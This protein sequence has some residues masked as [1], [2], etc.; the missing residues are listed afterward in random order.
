MSKV[1]VVVRREFL[2]TVRR[3][4]YLIVTFG[5]PFFAA[6]Y[7]GLFAL[8]PLI[9]RAQSARSKKGM[10]IVDLSGV[11]R[12]EVMEALDE[13]ARGHAEEVRS[14]AGDL[15]AAGAGA[16]MARTIL[17]AVT[18]A[19]RLRIFASREEALAALGEEGIDR[20]YLIPEDYL[21]TGAVEVYRTDSETF[22][23]GRARDNRVVERLLSRSL[24]A[25]RIPEDVRT[26]AERPIARE[27]LSAYVVGEDGEIE[28]LDAVRRTARWAIPAVFGVLLLMSLMTSAGYLLQ[29]VMEE[30]ENRVIEVILSSVRPDRLLFGKLLGLGAAGLLQLLV[31]IAVA[32][33]ATGLLAAAALA[34][35]D[36]RLFLACLLFFVLGFLLIG[37]LMTGTGALG[38]SARESQQLAAIW[39]VTAVLPPAVTWMVI[40]DAPNSWLARVLGWF[41]LSAPITMM[42]RLGTGQVPWW[43]VLVAVACLG[44]GVYLAVRLSAALFRLGLLMYGTRPS[45]RQIVRQLRNA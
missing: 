8:V 30:K 21:A 18:A 44:G 12:P 14:M 41:P 33:M 1:G 17:G 19:P 3:K 42:I 11:V 4:S 43:D 29:G 20:F 32:S 10:G 36:L 39:S 38:S 27:A 25:G 26:R 7:F 34:A 6:I 5:M 23:L 37:S 35:L 13:P 16:K 28:P 40:V 22:G 2:S 9:Y 45:F 15:E 31:W 24:L